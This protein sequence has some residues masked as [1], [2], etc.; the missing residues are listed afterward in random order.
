M[1]RI[2]RRGDW[3]PSVE[4]A[5]EVAELTGGALLRGQATTHPPRPIRRPKLNGTRQR[6]QVSMT[7]RSRSCVTQDRHGAPS[8][9]RTFKADSP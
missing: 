9:G 6:L 4:D 2:I 1:I 3:P 7:T 8:H 5:A